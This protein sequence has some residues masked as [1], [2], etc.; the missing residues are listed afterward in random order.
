M[1][2][3]TN[4]PMM[5]AITLVNALRFYA[6]T[7]MKVTRTATPTFML[8]LANEITG[9]VYRRG[10]Y[11]AAAEGVQEWIDARVAEGETLQTD[12]QF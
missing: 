1:T 3:I 9:H 5:R 4:M 8:K 12:K 2:T 6:K 10:Q 11:E 7:G